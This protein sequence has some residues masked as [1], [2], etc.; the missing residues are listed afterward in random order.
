[1]KTK[2]EHIFVRAAQA[3]VACGLY[4]PYEWLMN[5]IRMPMTSD[6]VRTDAMFAFLDFFKGCDAFP[7][8]PIQNWTIDKMMK[9][10]EEYYE[11]ARRKN[12]K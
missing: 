11:K 8:D 12:E 1:M 5:Y 4:H 2:N 10:I 9:A 3:G 6:S 7:E